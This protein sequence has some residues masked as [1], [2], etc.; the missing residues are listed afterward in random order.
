MRQNL[1]F[2]C[3]QTE[4]KSESSSSEKKT[5]KKKKSKKTKKSDEKENISVVSKKFQGDNY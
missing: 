3:F 2:F 1:G 4:T 5:S